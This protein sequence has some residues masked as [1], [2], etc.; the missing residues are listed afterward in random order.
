MIAD[1]HNQQPKGRRPVH[2][3]VYVTSVYS[4][5]D[6]ELPCARPQLQG[7]WQKKKLAGHPGLPRFVWYLLTAPVF[8]SVSFAV[9]NSTG[10]V[11]A[12]FGTNQLR[13]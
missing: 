2:T 6:P 12:S 1:A 4:W 7:L 8:V 3:C 13:R 11:G 5:V 10:P 9:Q